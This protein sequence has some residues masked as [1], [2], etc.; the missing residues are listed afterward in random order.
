SLAALFTANRATLWPLLR[1]ILLLGGSIL[2]LVCPLLLAIYKASNNPLIGVDV[3]QDSFAS[4]DL[5]GY[6]LPLHFS[7][8]FGDFTRAVI[9]PYKK[10]V[11]MDIETSV[12]LP[13][14]GLLLCLLALVKPVGAA[15][16]WLL[17]AFLCV[18][19]SLGPQLRLWGQT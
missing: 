19:F 6:F 14:I 3:N 8:L 9:A 17:F 2:L 7:R 12:S 11:T 10:L 1:R 13:L 15:R 4:P 5:V 16:R 18:I